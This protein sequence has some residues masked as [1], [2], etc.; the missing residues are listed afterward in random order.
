[1]AF[2]RLFGTRVAVANLELR[3]PL[4]GV[5]ELGLIN[6]PIVPI[7]IAP[8]LDAGLAWTSEE[9]PTLDFSRRTDARVPVFSTGLSARANI[10]G[11]FV[12]E[13][14]YAYPFQRP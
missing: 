2:S 10:L 3:I 4:F 7:E 12:L 13:A 14:Y 11:Y 9:T 1:P 5:S 6:F 8:F